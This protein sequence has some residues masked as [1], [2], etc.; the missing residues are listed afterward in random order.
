ML[1]GCVKPHAM[2]LYEA[3]CYV[4]EPTCYVDVDEPT[5]YVDV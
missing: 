5:C 2:W 3:T 1:C 4:D